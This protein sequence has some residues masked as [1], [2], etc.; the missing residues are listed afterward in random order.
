MNDTLAKIIDLVGAITIIILL[1]IP[2]YFF[3]DWV[4]SEKTA[5]VLLALGV[6]LLIGSQTENLLS[7]FRLWRERASSKH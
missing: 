7:R 1:S 3:L 5:K 4:L 6:A 2:L